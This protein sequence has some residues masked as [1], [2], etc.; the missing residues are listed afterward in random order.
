M[1]FGCSKEP[2]HSE[3]FLSFHTIYMFWLRNKKSIFLSTSL[4]F[5]LLEFST[6]IINK[7]FANSIL[8]LNIFKDDGDAIILCLQLSYLFAFKFKLCFICQFLFVQKLI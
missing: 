4:H 3:G 2:S 1:C 6:L 8:N 5:V 7:V